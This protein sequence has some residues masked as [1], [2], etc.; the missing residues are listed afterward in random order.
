ML[1]H[2]RYTLFMALQ[3]DRV[4]G[5]IAAFVDDLAVE[6]WHQKIGL[7]G[8]YECIDDDE[9]SH[10][11]LYF[12]RDW[13][14]S[15]GMT[16]MRG[17]WSFASQEWGLIV[18]GFAPPPVILAPYNPPYY[19]RQMTKFGLATGND[20]LVY[21]I[22]ARKGYTFPERYL[23][24]TEII[25]KRSG[26][27]VRAIDM[28]HLEADVMTIMQLANQSIADN[29][30][31]YPVTENEA[32]AMARDLK[33][34]INPAACLIAQNAEG[35]PI[36]FAMS[37]PDINLILKDLNGRRLSLRD[38]QT[39]HPPSRPEA[40]PHVGTGRSTRVPGSGH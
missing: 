31:F 11:L 25:R 36:G 10:T 14:R 19:N 38:F 35:R 5:R 21:E 32:R 30:G 29:W 33:Q 24:L 39:P 27:S 18:E 12:A 3:E 26:V 16:A 7:F 20:L 17:P 34:V 8:S 40:V 37:L 1:E 2:C 28:K 9:V 6:H 22:D 15:Q 4:V 23:H 13:L